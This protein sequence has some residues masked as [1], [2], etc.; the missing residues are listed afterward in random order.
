MVKNKRCC[1]GPCDNDTRYPQKLVKRNT[2]SDIKW[3]KLPSYGD[4]E[5]VRIKREKWIQ[6]I[7][8]DREDFV[9]D[10]HANHYVSHV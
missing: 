2:V 1:V 4:I 3:H 8:K 6:A 7:Q 9:P 10:T 5:K